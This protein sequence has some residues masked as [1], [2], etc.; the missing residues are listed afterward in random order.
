MKIYLDH[1]VLDALSKG[2]FRLNPPEGTVWIYSNETLNEIKRSGDR[3]FLDVLRTLKAKKIEL[4]LD[5]AFRL[6]GD[7]YIHEFRDPHDFYQEWL[8]AT[9]QCPIDEEANLQ[10]LSRLAGGDNHS[11]IL[12]Y[13]SRIREQIHNLLVSIHIKH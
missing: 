8:E 13:P 3:R 7:A 4:V 5:G 11:E 6:T 9:T 1:N 2:H 12:Q 10:L